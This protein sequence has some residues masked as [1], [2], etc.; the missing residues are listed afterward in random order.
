MGLNASSLSWPSQFLWAGQVPKTALLRP[1]LSRLPLL[2]PLRTRRRLTPLPCSQ[3][4]GPVTLL[5]A[6]AHCSSPSSPPP[7]PAPLPAAELLQHTPLGGKSCDFI[8]DVCMLPS[9]LSSS[10][11]H[12]RVSPPQRACSTPVFQTSRLQFTELM[13]SLISPGKRGHSWA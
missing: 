9:R 5:G 12:A 8:T 6:S 10:S 13:L 2:A 3:S 4:Q 7:P 11:L 1:S